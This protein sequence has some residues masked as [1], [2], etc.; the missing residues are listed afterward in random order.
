M[1]PKSRS[2]FQWKNSVVLNNWRIGMWLCF[3]RI[4]LLSKGRSCTWEIYL[5]RGTNT[6]NQPLHLDLRHLWAFQSLTGETSY[7]FSKSGRTAA[8]SISEPWPIGAEST[9][10]QWQLACRRS[11][12]GAPWSR[13]HC[14]IQCR[15]L[16][17][18]WIG[19]IFGVDLNEPFRALPSP[20][21][22]P[23]QFEPRE[24]SVGNHGGRWSCGSPKL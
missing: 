1:H 14:A 3:K 23:K 12:E 16:W 5:S 9:L 21:P 22:S 19:R 20:M 4:F 7:T 11:P 13:G 17:R 24:V 10:D 15:I 18:I 8:F 6:L 2:R